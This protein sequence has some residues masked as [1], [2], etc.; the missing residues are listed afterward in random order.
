MHIS[1]LIDVL[2]EFKLT[3]GD[4]SVQVVVDSNVLKITNVNVEASENNVFIGVAKEV[5]K[6]TSKVHDH[7][8]G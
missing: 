2:Q 1:K 6:Q 5:S 8:P 4:L 7:Q 3:Y